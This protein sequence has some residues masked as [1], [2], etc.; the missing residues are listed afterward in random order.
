MNVTSVAAHEAPQRLLTCLA[1]KPM[2]G[3]G[4]ICHTDQRQCISD[5]LD[6]TS[7]AKTQDTIKA[8]T[9]R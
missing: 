7:L 8:L 5:N 1:E 3:V 6:E 4:H 9:L 2:I